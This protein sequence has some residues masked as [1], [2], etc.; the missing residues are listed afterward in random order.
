MTLNCSITFSCRTRYFL[1]LN[2][3]EPY[4]PHQGLRSLIAYL[5]ERRR[6]M[7]KTIDANL[8]FI[9]KPSFRTQRAEAA[10]YEIQ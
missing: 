6:A 8:K 7:N 5:P 3:D 4:N 2:C 10:R 9:S 1:E